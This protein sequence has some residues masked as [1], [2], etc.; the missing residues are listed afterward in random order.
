MP[1]PAQDVRWVLTDC[2]VPGACVLPAQAGK[3]ML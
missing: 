2:V 1:E 3:V